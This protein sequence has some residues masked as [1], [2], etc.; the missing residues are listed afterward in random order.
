MITPFAKVNS[1]KQYRL[2]SDKWK[3]LY[4]SYGGGHK[5][6]TNFKCTYVV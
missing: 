1:Q 4:T 3:T 5:D 2:N 6:F